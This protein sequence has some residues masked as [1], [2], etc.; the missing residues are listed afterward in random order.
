MPPVENHLYK[1][2]TKNNQLIHPHQNCV[3]TVLGGLSGQR[4]L[5]LCRSANRHRLLGAVASPGQAALLQARAVW[6][7]KVLEAPLEVLIQKG[8]EHRVQAAVDVAQ[9]NA[10]VPG[11]H[12]HQVL[13]VDPHHGSDHDEDLDGR[14]AD[15]ENHH[16]H[17]DHAGDPSKV[18]VFL[19]GARQHAYALEAQDHQAVADGDDQHGDHKSEDEHTDYHHCV[20]VQLRFWE[21]ELA[22]ILP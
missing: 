16:D 12:H 5:S 19:F 1:V 8:V 22:C 2:K 18:P 3:M 4:R 20:P 14:P 11:C 13:L 10:Q 21:L 15:D 9:C 7:A 17:Q 6:Q